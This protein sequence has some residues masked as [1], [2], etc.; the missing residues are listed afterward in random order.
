MIP[1]S[2]NAFISGSP[3]VVNCTLPHCMTCYGRP[4]G[5]SGDHSGCR[6]HVSSMTFNFIFSFLILKHPVCLNRRTIQVSQ[7]R[8]WVFPVDYTDGD[9]TTPKLDG[10]TKHFQQD[11]GEVPS[12]DMTIIQSVSYRD[13]S[14]SRGR[15]HMDL[16][17]PNGVS[18]GDIGLP[19][20][21]TEFQR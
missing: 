3:V 8:R 21:L 13:R 12:H 1:V 9:T 20:P 11:E 18:E 19:T 15:T 14:L 16:E 2:A 7:T 6:S 4:G 5:Y 10:V 17:D